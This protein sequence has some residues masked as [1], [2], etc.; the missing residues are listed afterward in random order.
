MSAAVRDRIEAAWQG[1]IS[2]CQ[3]GKPVELLSMSEGHVGLSAY[4]SEAGALPLRDYVPALPGS[5]VERFRGSCR[6]HMVRSEPDDDINYSV[7]ALMLLEEAGAELRTEDVGRAWLRWLP[8]GVTFT[9]E[10]AAYRTLLDRGRLPDASRPGARVVRLR[11]PAWLRSRRVR[12]QRVQRLDR[13][14]DPCRPVRLG[15]S[16]P[17]RAGGA[18]GA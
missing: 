15:L 18:T 10:R 12:G 11:N 5:P 16:G 1:R 17:S 8:A 6:D 3:L 4:L 2:G 7:L 14:P 13:C 9:A